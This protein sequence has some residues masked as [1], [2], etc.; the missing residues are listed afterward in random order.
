MIT[1]VPR[2][3][4]KQEFLANLANLKVQVGA[5]IGVWK[6]DFSCQILKMMPELKLYLVDS[7]K[8]LSKEEYEDVLSG[9]SEETFEY[10]Y[11]MVKALVRPYPGVQ[12]LR[13]RSL[14][15]LPLI[16]DDS[17]DF[18]FID[19]NHK[20][21][22]VKADIEG[23]FKKVKKGGI[24]SGHDF[25]FGHWGVVRAVTELSYLGIQEVIYCK[26]DDI[27]VTLKP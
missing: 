5:E 9:T 1:L 10:M 16:P 25:D 7:W 20:Y 2:H 26:P 4:D 12:I 15:A 14:E 27:W 21:E 23:W 17:L 22:F 8:P 13:M 3:W 11:Q 18:V 19:A 6:G 24:I